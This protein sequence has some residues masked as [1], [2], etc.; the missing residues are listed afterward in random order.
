MAYSNNLWRKSNNVI[1]LVLTL[2]MNLGIIPIYS[3]TQSGRV[4]SGKIVVE[5]EDNRIY[6][7]GY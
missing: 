2:G 7:R 6:G 1:Q 4:G 5:R 3:P